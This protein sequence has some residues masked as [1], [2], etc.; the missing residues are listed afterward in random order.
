LGSP[1]RRAQTDAPQHLLA[2][3]FD[4]SLRVFVALIGG[5]MHQ[6]HRPLTIG[7]N[8]AALPVKNS[9]L[10]KPWAPPDSAGGKTNSTSPLAEI[11]Q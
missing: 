2:I 11:S 8:V 7:S 9:E 3:S 4:E 6:R 1:R 10:I 5:S